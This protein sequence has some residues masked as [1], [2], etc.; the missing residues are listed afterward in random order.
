MKTKDTC[1]NL[2]NNSQLNFYLEIK[3]IFC[4]LAYDYQTCILTISCVNYSILFKPSKAR[5]QAQCMFPCV[6]THSSF[7]PQCHGDSS[8][9]PTFWLQLSI[10]TLKYKIASNQRMLDILRSHFSSILKIIFTMLSHDVL[11]SHHNLNQYM[12]Y[13]L[14]E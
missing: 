3:K 1:L 6:P 9:L 10:P 14:Q 11:V 7:L 12:N 8:V 2:L 13:L 5:C 4:N